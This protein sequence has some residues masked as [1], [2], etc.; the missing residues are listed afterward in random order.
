MTLD[1][2]GKVLRS[3]VVP[4]SISYKLWQAARQKRRGERFFFSTNL[5]GKRIRYG[6][7]CGFS[8]DALF[9]DLRSYEP[10]TA[11]IL[12]DIVVHDTEPVIFDVGANNGQ[13]LILLKSLNSS[14]SVHC[15]EP[16]PELAGFLEE[17]VTQNSFESVSINNTMVGDRNGEA[18]LYFVE[19]ATDTASSVKGFQPTF[20]KNLN[21]RQ[22]SLDS[23]VEGR[24]LKKVSL[25]KI[26]VEGG[27]LEVLRG[28][29]SVLSQMRPNIILE[30]LYTKNPR[31][32]KRQE[33][34]VR[35]LE[36]LNYGFF[37][38]RQEGRLEEQK[39]VEPDPTYTFLNYLVSP[40]NMNATS[41]AP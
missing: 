6:G 31:H 34:A 5:F 8:D 7:V 35:I 30:L 36:E 27:E 1:I 21:A 16:F 2:I 41:P 19:G 23:Y 4:Q 29:R 14:A 12:A 3:R 9:A 10:E 40:K 11:S 18:E 15:F 32:L 26:D 39:R 17:L 13:F 38:I 22:C 28:A 24:Q 37:Q 33:Q 20:N 25:I